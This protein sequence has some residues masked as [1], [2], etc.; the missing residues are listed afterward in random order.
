M[1]RPL[2][3]W[4]DLSYPGYWIDK[5]DENGEIDY[6]QARKCTD[7]D[8]AIKWGKENGYHMVTPDFCPVDQIIL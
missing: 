4:D 2:V 7:L 1:S 3:V 6:S 5:L 8:T